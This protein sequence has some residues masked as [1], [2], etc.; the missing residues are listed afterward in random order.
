M[1]HIQLPRNIIVGKNVLGKINEIV[2]DFDSVL[3]VSGPKVNEIAGNKL[4]DYLESEEILVEKAC[5]EEV[6]KVEEKIREN[7]IDIVVGVGGGTVIDV[8]KF[9]A[10]RSK[11]P[12]I[13]VPTSCAHDGIASPMASL[14]KPNGPISIKAHAPLGIIADIDVI[15]KAPYKF[16]AAGVGDIIAKYSAVKDWKLGHILKGE[17]YGDYASSLSSMVAEVVLNNVQEI[18]EKTDTGIGV[19]LEALISSGAAMGIAGSSRPASGSEHKFSHGLDL[20][21][22]YPALHGEQ[23]GVGT[24]IMSYLQGENWNKIKNALELAGCPTTGKQLGVDNETMLKAMLKA[25]EIRPERYT[26]IE[27]IKLDK[28]IAENALHATGVIE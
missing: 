22:N 15:S 1:K 6:G 26:I 11:I 14:K 8:A 21:A 12:Y 20:V 17:Y 28:E 24:I 25:R 27:H 5:M 23:C 7:R 2:A 4:K 16:I 10:F 18:K 9:A 19:L 13:S 3:V